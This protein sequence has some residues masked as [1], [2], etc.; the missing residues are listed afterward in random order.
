MQ[1]ALY[2]LLDFL[3]ALSDLVECEAICLAASV[4]WFYFLFG[5]EAMFWR[6]SLF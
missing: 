1:M 6:C 4:R 2:W 3:F 5:F